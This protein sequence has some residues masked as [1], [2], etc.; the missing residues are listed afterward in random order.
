MSRNAFGWVFFIAMIAIMVFAG[1]SQT[2]GPEKKP[3]PPDVS[4]A[5]LVEAKFQIQGFT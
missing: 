5:A 4:K 1:P 3:I 2:S